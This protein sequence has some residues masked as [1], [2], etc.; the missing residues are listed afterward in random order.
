MSIRSYRVF[1][2]LIWT[3]V[4]SYVEFCLLRNSR[5]KVLLFSLESCIANKGEKFGLEMAC[6]MHLE[7]FQVVLSHFGLCFTPVWPV[8]VTG[9][10]G[11]SAGPVHML[12]TGLTGDV[13][14]SDRS[15]LSCCSYPVFKWCFACIRPGGV[16]LVQGE[17]A[18]VQ[19]ELFVVVRAIVWW[20]ALFA[21]ALFCL[22]CVEP[23]PLP[24]GSESCLLQVILLFGFDWLSIACWSFFLFVSFLF[25]SLL[26]LYVGAVNALIKGE[27]EDHVR[28]EDQWM[29]ASLC[30]EW[31]T[32]L[33]GL[34]LG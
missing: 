24:K 4:A 2:L 31:L 23:L 8:C 5:L 18:C 1:N 22:G 12:H 7:G 28:F 17:L 14:R 29:V 34:I 11:Q 6:W 21:W 32:T 25:F 16:A 33:C 20:F 30:D 3:C 13:D 10:T 27:I 19:G 9:L 26:L 15:G